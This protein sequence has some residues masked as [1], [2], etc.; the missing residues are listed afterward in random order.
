MD[1]HMILVV[2]KMT[3]FKNKGMLIA[4]YVDRSH[5]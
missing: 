2:W 4:S 5:Y 1:K 3:C